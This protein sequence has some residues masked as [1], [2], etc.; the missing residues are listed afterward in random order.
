MV[1]SQLQ[2][3]APAGWK[4]NMQVANQLAQKSR[5]SQVAISQCTLPTMDLY[6]DDSRGLNKYAIAKISLPH[7]G[8]R[9]GT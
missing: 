1:P 3:N 9:L 6:I 4:L 8:Q 7:I 5:L 2:S